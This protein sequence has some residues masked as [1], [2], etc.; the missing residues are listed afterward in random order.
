VVHPLPFSGLTPHPV[1]S[2]N[3]VRLFHP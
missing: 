2:V 1:H 3:P